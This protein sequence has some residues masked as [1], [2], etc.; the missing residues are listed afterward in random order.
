MNTLASRISFKPRIKGE[1]LPIYIEPIHMSGER[2]T[3][4]IAAIANTGDKHVF[5]TIDP[6][7]IRAMYQDRSSEILGI[8]DFALTS[9]EQFIAEEKSLHHWQSPLSGIIKGNVTQAEGVEFQHIIN[10]GI[11]RSSSLSRPYTGQEEEIDGQDQEQRVGTAIKTCLININSSYKDHINKVIDL[12]DIR[13]RRYSFIHPKYAANVAVASH[14]ASLNRALVKVLDIND[15]KA[16]PSSV[17]EQMEIII[18]APINK[19]INNFVVEQV[20]AEAKR[21]NLGC[22]IINDNPEKIAEFIHKK[23]AAG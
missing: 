3:I 14:N 23:I 15:L 8:I 11:Q 22:V 19:S 16:D 5:K 12:G 10:Q 6:N 2:F 20:K 21:Y 1:W 4:A 7:L 17:F 9:L 18:T 13:E